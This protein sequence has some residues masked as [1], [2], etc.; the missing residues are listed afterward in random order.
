MPPA[1]L[2]Y[3]KAIG[4]TLRRWRSLWIH[5]QRNR[6][7]NSNCPTKPIAIHTSSAGLSAC[8]YAAAASSKLSIPKSCPEDR[9]RRG[10]RP[11]RASLAGA[12]D[13]IQDKFEPLAVRVVDAA[14]AVQLAW[15]DLG[16]GH[17][18]QEWAALL[19][20]DQGEAASRVFEQMLDAASDIGELR[21]GAEQ[22]DK[23][24]LGVRRAR[25]RRRRAG[26]QAR[27]RLGDAGT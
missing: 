5:C 14:D 26:F 19:G 11:P 6:I 15:L 1:R 25:D 10:R 24:R 2:K 20:A 7:M 12:R 13:R 23:A 27:H 3:Q 22:E 21:A 17:Q 9:R 16:V 4:I 18:R 8:R